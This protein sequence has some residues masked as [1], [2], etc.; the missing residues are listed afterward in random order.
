MESLE[1]PWPATS[2]GNTDPPVQERPRARSSTAPEVYHPT[3][4]TVAHPVAAASAR[5]SIHNP[6]VLFMAAPGAPSTPPPLPTSPIPPRLPYPQGYV[7]HS[8]RRV[9]TAPPPVPPHPY[10][11]AAALPKESASAPPPPRPPRPVSEPPLPPAERD[12]TAVDADPE[13]TPAPETPQTPQTPQED[14]AEL[15]ELAAVLALSQAETLRQEK[16]QQ[17]ML[18]QEEADLARALEASMATSSWSN[19]YSS[20]YGVHTTVAGSSSQALTPSATE[21]PRLEYMDDAAFARML[22][23][24]E[25]ED[26][27]PTQTSFSENGVRGAFPKSP[28]SDAPFT[29]DPVGPSLQNGDLPLYSPSPPSASEDGEDGR[30]PFSSDGELAR[31]LAMEEERTLDL[32]RIRSAGSELTWVDQSLES[33]IL[34]IDS[35][36]PASVDA[37]NFRSPSGL[38]YPPEIIRQVSSVSLRSEDSDTT[39]RS[40]NQYLDADLLRGVSVGFVA[41]SITPELVPLAGSMP[42][43]IS[44][45]YGRC[46]PLHLQ[47][48]SWRHLL[49]LMA[50]LSGTRIEPTV[51]ALAVTRS[52]QMHLRTVVQFVRP[53]HSSSDWRTVLWFTIDHP[54]PNSLPGARKWTNGDVDCYT[55]PSSDSVPFPA[56]PISFPNMAMYLQAA[57]EES[58]RYINDSSSGVRKLAKMLEA[59]YPTTAEPNGDD[60]ER[61]RVG[62]LFKNL[63]RGGRKEKVKKGKGGNEDTYELVTPFVLDEWGP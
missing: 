41:P 5:S 57:L 42:N 47:A 44:L 21:F 46:P 1:N 2:W 18:S 54:V 34:L 12:D 51:E 15:A 27:T 32:P 33:S 23:A 43:I 28:K 61:S 30:P 45:P 37:T 7:L 26:P 48:P 40:A 6:D 35:P 63:I 36:R 8:L 11:Y 14:D 16:R 24:Q 19:S 22:A 10:T 62:G 4:L 52:A 29:A 20:A 3:L 56:L 25:R 39:Q 31:R 17:K 38:L 53:H 59:C 50:R 60:G 58:R 9:R 49:K 13:P 55:I